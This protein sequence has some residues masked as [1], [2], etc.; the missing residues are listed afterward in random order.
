MGDNQNVIDD[1]LTL[2]GNLFGN[3]LGARHEVKAQVQQHGEQLSRMLG[4]VTREEFDAAFAMLAKA[5]ILQD[6]IIGRI[7]VIEKQ[8]KISPSRKT[9]ST[10]KANLPSVKKDKRGNKRG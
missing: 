3:L 9:R 5:R 2:G 1:L 7:E 4:L 10:V 6:E 8:L